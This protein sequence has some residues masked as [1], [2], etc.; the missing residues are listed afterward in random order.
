M[1]MFFYK[2]CKEFKTMRLVWYCDLV[3]VSTYYLHWLPV[4]LHVDY[5]MLIYTYNAL[6]HH[7]PPYICEIVTK[8]ESRRQLRS[9]GKCVLIVPKVRTNGARSFL[10]ASA[11]WNDLC[12]D[13]LTEVDFVA[14]F[15]GRLKIHLF[16][17]RTVWSIL[18]YIYHY[19]RLLVF[20][21]FILKCIYTF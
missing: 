5:R 19:I 15:K 14:V 7:A 8:Y 16:N 13:C 10:D 4:E 18:L 2:S 17:S 9:S 21:L 3:K 1:V 20:I 11:T 12:D 6:Y